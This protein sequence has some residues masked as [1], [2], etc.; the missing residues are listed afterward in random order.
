MQVYNQGKGSTLG[1]KHHKKRRRMFLALSKTPP[2]TQSCT[3]TDTQTHTG[4]HTT[5]R[6]TQTHSDTHTQTHTHTQRHTHT[7][8]HTLASIPEDVMSQLR[9]LVSFL[10]FSCVNLRMSCLPG[11]LVHPIAHKL[12]PLVWITSLESTG[13]KIWTAEV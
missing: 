1:P 10:V 2:D 6:R 13:A 8:T 9:F 11:P 5:H 4:T 12:H 7:H 3:H